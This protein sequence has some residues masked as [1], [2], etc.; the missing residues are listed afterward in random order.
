MVII[1]ETIHPPFRSELLSAGRAAAGNWIYR[2]SRLACLVLI[3]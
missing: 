3:I 1:L 2:D